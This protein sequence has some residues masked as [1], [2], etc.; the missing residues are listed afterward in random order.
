MHLS[1]QR[2]DR[3]ECFADLKKGSNL[4][5]AARVELE[6]LDPTEALLLPSK[7]H[8]TS[9]S[10][11]APYRSGS[12]LWPAPNFEGD[13]QGTVSA[14]PLL[15]TYVAATEAAEAWTSQSG[16]FLETAASL[17]LREEV[18]FRAVGRRERIGQYHGTWRDVILI[19][20]RRAVA[21]R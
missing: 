9:C 11:S 20:R 7:R 6:S 4:A 5:N 17:A 14:G 13:Q 21:A 10:E 2:D 12:R 16:V 8:L 15:A 18:G 1:S 3:Y 19:D